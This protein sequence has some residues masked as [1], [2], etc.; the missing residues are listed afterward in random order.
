[1][2]IPLRVLI[3]EDSED[4]AILI[5]RELRRNGYDPV[6][7]RV[8]RPE[9][10]SAALAR[11]TWDVIIADYFMPH[12]DGLTALKLLQKSGLD[13][14]FIIVSGAIGEDIAVA[15]MKAGAHDY[16]MKDKLARL[17]PAVRRELREAKVRLARRQ[18][19][20]EREKLII[21]L[22]EALAKIKTLR[23][24]IPI[25][26]SCKKIRD[27]KG[28]WNQLEAYIQKHSEAEFTHGICPECAEKLYPEVYENDDEMKSGG[29]E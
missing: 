26:A 18:V 20:E 16:V 25:C 29:E 17:V 22:R 10:F 3:V 9:A 21:E 14:P 13:L 4:D 19:E 15:A 23:G 1:M 6:F 28:Y 12:F 5:T 27:D 2:S 24:L 8:D 11:Q 7:E